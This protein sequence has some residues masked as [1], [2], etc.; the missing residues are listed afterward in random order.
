MYTKTHIYILYITNKNRALS[1]YYTNFIYLY[2]YVFI[3]LYI[4]I[5]TIFCVCLHLEYNSFF[6]RVRVDDKSFHW[7]EQMGIYFLIN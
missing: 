5:F 2:I 4:Y 1:I 3:Y 7:D 6:H